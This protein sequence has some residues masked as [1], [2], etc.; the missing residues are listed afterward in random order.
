V[1]ALAGPLDVSGRT[2]L[3]TGA[4]GGIGR[5][6]AVLLRSLNARPVLALRALG[7]QAADDLVRTSPY[8][9]MMPARGFCRPAFIATGMRAR[10][11][12]MLLPGEWA[13][14]AAAHP[15]RFGRARD[16][17]HAVALLLAGTGRS[18]TGATLVADGGYSA[19]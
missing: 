5:D 10:L 11:R 17:A 1:D 14:L 16:M 7:I 13:A 12:D 4:S 2:V 6:T 3:V 9:G 15:L 19:Q 18:I 8:S